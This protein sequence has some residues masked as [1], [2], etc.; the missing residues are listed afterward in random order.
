MVDVVAVPDRLEHA[1]GEAQRQQVLHGLA[2]E[3]VVD[4]EDAVLGEDR[5]QPLVQ[6]PGRSEVGAEG[7]LGDHPS[8]LSEPEPADLVHRRF[9]RLRRQGEIDERL[10]I[11]AELLP[12]RGDLVS[13]VLE[14][15][16][17]AHE[18]QRR[19]E[20][21]PS[22]A[23]AGPAARVTNRIPRKLTE[24]LIVE[25]LAGCADD[26]EPL[27]HQTH[28]HQVVHPRQQLALGEVAGGAEEDDHLVLWRR[29][30]LL[31]AGRHR[32]EPMLLPEWRPKRTAACATTPRRSTASS[33]ASGAMS[34]SRC[35]T[36]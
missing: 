18:P 8:A 5:V 26:P 7:L 12:R 30:L 35:R 29:H 4:A 6:L 25:R 27:G 2:A 32:L 16:A 9:H 13:Q 23:I 14:T 11:L 15:V 10:G 20:A 31:L 34:G 33:A 1:V 28:S 19:G 21:L 36:R 24:F 3:V 22:L 17:D